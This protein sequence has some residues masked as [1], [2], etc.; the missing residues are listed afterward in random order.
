MAALDVYQREPLPADSPLLN[1]PN[2]VLTPHLGWPTD[3]GYASFARAACD[4]LFAFLDGR[5]VPTFSR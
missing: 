4:V 1:L 5:P 2:V 3:E